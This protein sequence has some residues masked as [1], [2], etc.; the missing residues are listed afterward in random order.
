MG[1][2]DEQTLRQ[3][4]SE[5]QDA[6]SRLPGVLHSRNSS[7]MIDYLSSVFRDEDAHT[8]PCLT[9][10]TD[11]ASDQAVARETLV[12]PQ[13]LIGSGIFTEPP[14]GV[15]AA[16]RLAAAWRSEVFDTRETT[17]TEAVELGWL[18][19]LTKTLTSPGSVLRIVKCKHC[20]MNVIRERHAS[21]QRRCLSTPA[22][23]VAPHHRA[24]EAAAMDGRSPVLPSRSALARKSLKC[25]RTL[26][27]AGHSDLPAAARRSPADAVE[28]DS[29]DGFEAMRRPMDSQVTESSPPLAYSDASAD[30]RTADRANARRHG[31]LAFPG[32]VRKYRSKAPSRRKRRQFN[33]AMETHKD[34]VGVDHS[35]Y[36]HDGEIMQVHHMDDEEEMFVPVV[37][38]Q[39][40]HIL[41]HY[42]ASQALP[43]QVNEVFLDAATHYPSMA[44]QIPTFSSWHPTHNPV[45]HSSTAGFPYHLPHHPPQGP[46]LPLYGERHHTAACV[47]GKPSRLGLASNYP[48]GG[49]AGIW[50]GGPHT[51]THNPAIEVHQTAIRAALHN[52]RSRP[53]A[54]P[55]MVSLNQLH[56]TLPNLE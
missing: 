36:H 8:V 54:P 56:D 49:P 23:Q 1:G 51:R 34:V 48:L 46:A 47:T 27:D 42:P 35:Q 11:T 38:P 55:K 30:G 53:P 5:L 41:Q 22:P 50:M 28:A 21:H 43:E 9:R 26:Q 19:A 40:A 15:R 31:P 29:G 37:T 12:Y 39:R 44:I 52:Q 10:N 14:E 45:R 13:S 3:L 33:F 20:N 25:K 24:R 32:Q 18:G 6:C 7:R 16:E 17:F 2:A 4:R